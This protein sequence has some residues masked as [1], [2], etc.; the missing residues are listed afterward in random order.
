SIRKVMGA[1]VANIVSLLSKSFLKLVI[2]AIFIAAPIGWICGYFFLQIF[3][4][5]VEIGVGMITL[6][7]AAILTVSLLV[8]GSQVIRVATANPANNLRAE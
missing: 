7:S 6:A 3:A 4:V 2:I 1:G 5:R 8:I